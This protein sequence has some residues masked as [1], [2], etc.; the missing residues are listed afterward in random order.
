[1]FIVAI[2]KLKKWEGRNHQVNIEMNFIL[3]DEKVNIIYIFK[4]IVFSIKVV[5]LKVCSQCS[6]YISLTRFTK[7]QTLYGDL[8]VLV[9]TKKSF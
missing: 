2:R 6:A 9:L 5:V 1:M 4:I 8:Y 7:L 3:L